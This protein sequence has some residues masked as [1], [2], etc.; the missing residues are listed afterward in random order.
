MPAP[1][2]CPV[3]FGDEKVI[4]EVSNRQYVECDSCGASLSTYTPMPHQKQ[5]HESVEEYFKTFLFGAFAVG[6]TVVMLNIVAEH[7]MT[8]DNAFTFSAMSKQEIANETIQSGLRKIIPDKFVKNFTNIEGSNKDK[9]SH[10]RLINNSYLMVQSGQVNLNANKFRSLEFTMVYLEEMSQFSNGDFYLELMT[11]LNRHKSALRYKKDPNTGELLYNVK[12][13]DRLKTTIRT[14]IV[15]ANFSKMVGNSNPDRGSY[16]YSD[17]VLRTRWM[18]ENLEKGKNRYLEQVFSS[19]LSIDDNAVVHFQKTQDNF[20]LP[21]DY[22]ATLKA[23]AKP[24]WI[25]EYIECSFDVAHNLIYEKFMECKYKPEEFDVYTSLNHPNSK[26]L[27][28]MD[29]GYAAPTVCI[30]AVYDGP[31]DTIYLVDEYSRT[32]STVMENARGIKEMIELYSPMNQLDMP[33]LG[34]PA[35][36]KRTVSGEVIMNS[37]VQAGLWLAAAQNTPKLNRISKVDSYMRAGKLRI[38]EKCHLLLEELF[39]YKWINK[40]VNGKNVQKL[41]DGNDDAC[42]SL[43]YLMTVMPVDPY[44]LRESMS[45]L[46]LV[47]PKALHSA[48]NQDMSRGR[49]KYSRYMD[50]DNVVETDMWGSPYMRRR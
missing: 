49:D 44:D 41:P 8:L 14:P 48:Y 31:S 18:Y 39:N 9:P 17:I 30:M 37:Y 6:K 3:C 33:I 47:Q 50:R 7:L 12:R 22:I 11:R 46:G 16:I 32:K 2:V 23:S 15:E 4:R 35:G 43:S 5:V 27:A 13:D 26:V 28:C 19:G 25:K 38:S 21:D 45:R 20:Y 29:F 40:Q 36:N 24:E 34:D 42:D 10:I 1:L